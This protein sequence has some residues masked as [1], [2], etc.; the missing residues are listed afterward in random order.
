MRGAALAD[1]A[2]TNQLEQR[3]IVADRGI[4]T[5]R[6]GIALAYNERHAI[7]D[8]FADRVYANYRGLAHV[9]GY[10]KAPA[11]DSTGTYYRSVFQGIDGAEE[12]FNIDLAGRNGT[13]LTETDAHGSVVSQSVV[14][15]AT[16]GNKLVLSIDASLTQGLYDAI[17]ERADGS[18]FQ[19]GAGV[20]MD[21]HTGEILAMTSYPE[22]SQNALEEGDSAAFAAF[23][24]DRRLPFLNR[25]TDGLYAPGSIVK[26]I[27]AAAALTEGVITPEKQILSTGSISVPNPYD[28]EHP[29]IFR[30]WR[31]HGWVDVRKAIAVSSDVYFYEVGGGYPGQSGIGIDKLDAYFRMFGFAGDPG[32]PGFTKKTGNIP[33]PAWK[34]T[35]FP[36]DPTWRLGDTYHTAIGQY[37]VQVTPLQA[38]REAAA[39]ANGGMLLNPVLVASTTGASV[40]LPISDEVLQIVREGMRQGVTDGIAQSVKFDFVDVAAKTGTAQIGVHNEYINSWMIGFFPYEHPRYAYAIVLERGP[41]HTVVGAPAAASTLFSWMHANTPQYLQ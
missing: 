16:S 1:R 19:G 27:V 4:I 33:T 38:V 3:S 24:S 23:A 31:A 26:P 35:A 17:V 6:T 39:L 13:Q 28:K 2:R 14:E 36:T 5:D 15:P 8:P 12:V 10:V 37:G 41:A 20:I 25:A 34:K 11:K 29:S 7:D 18:K 40:K 22:Y 21:I 32:L 9:V 30:D